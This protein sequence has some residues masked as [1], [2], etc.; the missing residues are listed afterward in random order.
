[1]PDDLQRM[2]H[3]RQP[4]D[5]A[6]TATVS[7]ITQQVLGV[8]PAPGG[9]PEQSGPIPAGFSICAAEAFRSHGAAGGEVFILLGLA[10]QRFPGLSNFRRRLAGAA[11][12]PAVSNQR[13]PERITRRWHGQTA[14]TERATRAFRHAVTAGTGQPFSEAAA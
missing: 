11:Y 6:V 12:P 9:N 13:R 14:S 5:R 2:A 1:M 7:Q 10:A 3:R 8:L 4:S